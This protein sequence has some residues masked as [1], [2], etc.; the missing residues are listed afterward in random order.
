MGVLNVAPLQFGG[1][2]NRRN[3]LQAAV[4]LPLMSSARQ[5]ITASS[6]EAIPFDR[7]I[8]RQL[9]RDAANK[10]YKAADS[11]RCGAAKSC[12]SKFSF[13]TEVSSTR[14]ALTS[15]KWQTDRRQKYPTGPKAS[16][17]AATNRRHPT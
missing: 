6:A 8:V 1:S 3:L 12:L 5:I 2:L 14:R 17:L 13:S 16:R 7:S 15:T 11:G 4:S 10:P 9:A